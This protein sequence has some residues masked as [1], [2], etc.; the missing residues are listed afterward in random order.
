MRLMPLGGRGI[1]HLLVEGGATLSAALL[2]R[3]L[4]DKLML[5]IAPKIIGGDGLSLVGPCGVDHLDQALLWHTLRSRQVGEDVLL[6]A[7]R[8]DPPA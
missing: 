1:A 5:F 8:R 2:Q 6:E 4:I 3:H 7:Y